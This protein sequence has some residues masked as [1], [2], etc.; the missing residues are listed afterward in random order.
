ME[1]LQYEYFNDDRARQAH[2]GYRRPMFSHM[3][4]LSLGI[5]RLPSAR[6]RF[7]IWCICRWV[8]SGYRRPM[9][10]SHMVYLSLGIVWFPN[11]LSSSLNR[12]KTRKGRAV[13]IPN[14]N[15]G[16]PSLSISWRPFTTSL[17]FF[18]LNINFID[19]E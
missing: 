13:W 3:V 11:R 10:F 2:T 6:D 4:Y 16:F 5:V 17:H 8:L 18:P 9:T 12:T 15:L 14:D 19:V 7:L 1:P